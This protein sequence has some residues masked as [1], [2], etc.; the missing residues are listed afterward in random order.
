MR[1]IGNIIFILI[2]TTAS[3]AYFMWTINNFSIVGH[4]EI[5]SWLFY[6]A[7]ISICWLVFTWVISLCFSDT[8]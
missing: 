5:Y 6:I 3:V 8:L 7:Y 2:Y 4:H 1:V